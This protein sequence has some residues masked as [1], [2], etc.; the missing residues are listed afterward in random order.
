MNT[1]LKYPLT[2]PSYW[3]FTIFIN[4]IY[5]CYI[6]YILWFSFLK[7]VPLNLRDP[8]PKPILNWLKYKRKANSWTSCSPNFHITVLYLAFC[9]P[10]PPTKWKTVKDDI[11]NLYVH[12]LCGDKF[13]SHVLCSLWTISRSKFLSL[14]VKKK[15][16]KKN[17]LTFQDC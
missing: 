7:L 17:L 6:F 2:S 4:S 9:L 15:K 11:Q 14:L 8:E 13:F 3:L 16:Q 12:V 1:V 5:W 10:P